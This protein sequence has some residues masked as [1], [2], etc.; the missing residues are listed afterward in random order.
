MS[1][2]GSVGSIGGSRPVPHFANFPYGSHGSLPPPPGPYQHPRHSNGDPHMRYP[3]HTRYES[4]SSLPP[5]PPPPLPPGYIVPYP[6]HSLGQF[7]LPYASASHPA[8]NGF[9]ATR[10][11]SGH[12]QY[13]P[14]EGP[15]FHYSGGPPPNPNYPPPNPNYPPP[16]ASFEAGIGSPPPT[17][18]T[19]PR[20]TSNKASPPYDIDPAV[21]SAWSGQDQ[22]VIVKTMSAEE[23][24]NSSSSPDRSRDTSKPDIVKRATSNQNETIET[25]PDIV[26]ESVKRAALNRDNSYASNRLKEL[27]FPGQFKNGRF[28]ATKEV[29]ELS[30]DMLKSSLH[31]PVSFAPV[32]RESTF[33]QLPP[34]YLDESPKRLS[35][36]D[37]T[38]TIDMIA[39][40]L[41]VKPLALSGASRSSTIEALALDFDES[42][43]LVKPGLVSRTTTMEAV[44]Q[45]LRGDF[46]K[47]STLTALDR[48]TTKDMMDLV[49]EPIPDDGPDFAAGKRQVV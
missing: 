48:M 13:P 17:A 10:N 3:S 20:Q 47:P 7:P 11:G 49:N 21:A 18:T 36:D 26:G 29:N 41:M 12:W 27:T 33:D 1:S 4:W 31:S 5:G 22:D 38:A 44:F 30:D 25:K 2:Y 45:E 6:D 15:L 32:E 8:Y 35:K 40:D 37:R 46:T 28:D 9:E 23:F 14:Q 39:M 43:L 16:S 19:S 34:M 24:G 42:D